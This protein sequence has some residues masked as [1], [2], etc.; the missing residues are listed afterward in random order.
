VSS[1]SDTPTTQS[2]SFKNEASDTS[3]TTEGSTCA[4]DYDVIVVGA[5]LGGLTAAAYLA[6]GGQSV[7]LCDRNSRP[8]GLAVTLS[9]NGFTLSH[10]PFLLWGAYPGGW[11]LEMFDELGLGADEVPLLPVDPISRVLLPGGGFTIPSNPVA[12]A[13]LLCRDFPA[14]DT[15]IRDF[16]RD[17]DLLVDEWHRLS[18]DLSHIPEGTRMDALRDKTFDDYLDQFIGKERRLRALLSSSWSHWGLPPSRVSGLLAA[19]LLGFGHRGMVTPRGGPSILSEAL[20]VAVR[21]GGGEVRLSTPVTQI[22][23]EQ[24]RARGVRLADG[25]V[26]SARTVISNASATQTFLNLVGR[27]LL[28]T[29]LVRQLGAMQP[30]MSAFQ[31]FL[32]VDLDL[33]AIP[34][35]AA[36]TVVL[37]DDDQEEVFGRAIQG[38]FE[39]SFTIFSYSLLDPTAAPPGLH[40]LKLLGAGPHKRRRLE[41]TRDKEGIA[42][43][44]I[45]SAEQVIP[46]LGDHIVW[47]QISTPLDLQ[48][49]TDA[50]GAAIYGWSASPSQIGPGRLSRR[51]PIDGLYL[52]GA[53]T[54]P[55][56]GMDLCMLSGRETAALVLGGG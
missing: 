29:S 36:E 22:I 6:R 47:Q 23:V 50:P 5:G 17:L 21:R 44:M 3:A 39:S 55:F 42:Q 14:E 12:F 46:G 38:E 52:A 11:T 24:G 15:G 25:T 9:A 2:R 34:D 45:K 53:W 37:S 1:G 40:A 48:E 56:A 18:P 26:V 43:R 10:C 4:V 35:L 31:V 51:S 32:G 20:A 54:G 27:D 33:T 19:L 16:F 7:L 28:S 49:V 8:G 30:S 41:W 13:D